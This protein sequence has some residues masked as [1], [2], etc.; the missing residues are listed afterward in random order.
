MAPH[1]VVSTWNCDGI[2][3]DNAVLQTV[4]RGVGVALKASKEAMKPVAQKIELIDHETRSDSPLNSHGQGVDAPKERISRGLNFDTWKS[5]LLEYSQTSTVECRQLVKVTLAV[6]YWRTKAR[7]D[8]AISPED[9]DMIWSLLHTAIITSASSTITFTANRSAQGFLAIPLCSLISSTGQ[10]EE[11][12]R[13]HVW[14][15]D[16]ERGVAEVAI[17]AHQS[18]AQSWTL[19][20]C[21]TDYTYDFDYVSDTAVATHAAYDCCYVDSSKPG[22][23]SAGYKTHQISS[24]V[25]NTGKLVGI[26]PSGIKTYTRDMC[27]SVPGGRHHKSVVPG[28]RFHATLFVFDAHRGYQKDSYVLGPIDGE[29]YT[30]LRDPKGVTPLL[31]AQLTDASRTWEQLHDLRE[32]GEIEDQVIKAYYE[33]YRGQSYL[34]AGDRRTAL[35]YFTPIDSSSPAHAFARH[36]SDLHRMLIKA[37]VEAGAG[38]DVVDDAGY[39]PLDYAILAGDA[40]SEALILDGLRWRLSHDKIDRRGYEAQASKGFHEV[41]EQRLQ[42]ILLSNGSG[43][44]HRMRQT[45]ANI[46]ES[47]RDLSDSFDALRYVWYKDFAS[48]TRLPRFSDGTLHTFSSQTSPQPE[49]VVYIAYRWIYKNAVTGKTAND[50]KDHTQYRRMLRAVEKYLA[51][52]PNVVPERLGIWMDSSCVDRKNPL[53]G[54]AALPI[55]LAQCDA[56]ITIEDEEFWDRA[57]CS[58]EALMIQKL[59]QRYGVHEWYRYKYGHDGVGDAWTLTEAAIDMAIDPSSKSMTWEEDR[60]K[61]SFL[62]RQARLL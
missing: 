61:I 42:P 4:L 20:G 18:F 58:V 35:A 45:Y 40:E 1:T 2:I 12:W 8:I 21:G 14:L 5:A 55:N 28:R 56:L 6:A 11:L 44:L 23:N 48:C 30:Q 60:D 27:Y 49:H 32:E 34:E 19:S 24:T 31:A 3:M 57:W 17:H 39:K 54:I 53:P 26:S 47:N 46:L 43:K 36:P 16:G 9:L 33:F 10:I 7:A 25:M 13:Y 38:L 41:F 50:D 62:E 29:A 37:M 15:P 22:A 52:H 59:R 51:A